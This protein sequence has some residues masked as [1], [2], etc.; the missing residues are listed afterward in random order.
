MDYN[1]KYLKYKNKYNKVVEELKKKGINH[2]NPFLIAFTAKWCGHCHKFMPLFNSMKSKYNS[3]INFINYDSDIDKDKMQKYNISG[4]P[5]LY[6]EYN[7]KLVEY[8]GDRS[9]KEIINFV[10]KHSSN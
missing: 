5:T 3:K 10:D 1:D 4:Y 9:E 2:K 6:F 8:K 7:N